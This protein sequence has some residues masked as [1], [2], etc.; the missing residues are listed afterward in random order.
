MTIPDKTITVP[1]IPLQAGTSAKWEKIGYDNLL[2][3][4]VYNVKYMEVAWWVEKHPNHMW[5]F[6]DVPLESDVSINYDAGVEL[7]S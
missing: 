4:W 3:K 6:Y 7:V 5:K 1:Y 2:D